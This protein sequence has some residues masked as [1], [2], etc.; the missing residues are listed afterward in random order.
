MNMMYDLYVIAW[1]LQYVVQVKNLKLSTWNRDKRGT[2]QRIA[3]IFQF[4]F[5]LPQT[6]IQQNTNDIDIYILFRSIQ[7]HKKQNNKQ[8]LVDTHAYK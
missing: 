1:K 5:F 7:N 2:T 4:Q 8:N 6:E 3:L